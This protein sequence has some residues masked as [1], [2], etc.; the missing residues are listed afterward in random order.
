[1]KPIFIYSDSL[2]NSIS[3]FMRVGGISIFPFVILREKHKHPKSSYG[4]KRSKKIHNHETIHFR[5]QLEMLVIFFYIW[6]VVEFLIKLFI[7][8]SKAYRNLLHEKEAYENDEDNSYLSRR[9]P[10]A[11]L[12]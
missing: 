3:W 7:Y 10:Y 6:Y 1:M 9:K 12:T 8:G 2:L 11:W 5:Q 4:F